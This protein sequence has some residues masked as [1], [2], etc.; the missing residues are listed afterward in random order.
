MQ[1]EETWME[2]HALHRHGWS[3][4][5]L[6]R[7]FGLNWRT[8]KK[9]ATRA[10]PPRYRPR[11]RPAELTAAQTGPRRA[12][13]DRLPR[14]AGDRPPARARRRVRVHRVVREPAP[15]G[16]RP[17]PG[18]GGGARPALRDG[19][20]RADPG[21]L[22]RLSAPGRSATGRP[23]LFAFV[24]ILGC[25][26]M[27]AHPLRDRQDAARRPCATS[28]AAS[29][30]S[31]GR[32]PTSCTTGTRRSWR[33]P[34]RT[35]RRS[36]RPSGSTPRPCSAR[37]P[38]PAGRT[39]PRPRARS[40]ASSGR[41]RRTSSPGSP[42]RCSPSA[43]RSPG[44]TRRRG[45]WAL[46]VHARRR[47]RTTGR[48]V[49][50]AWEAERPLLLPVSGRLV[51]R[52]EGADTLV[53]LPTPRER[54][55]GC[56][57]RPAR[58]SRSGRSRCTPSSPD[59]RPPSPGS[60]P[61]TPAPGSTSRTSASPRRRSTSPPS[62]SGPAPRPRPRSRSSS[63]CSRPRSRRPA[64]AGCRAGCGSPTTRS[65]S[66]SRSSSSTSSP[67]IDRAVIAELSTLRFVE[68]HRNALFLGPP[69]VGKSHLAIA[70][71]IAAT[72][73]GYRTYFTTAADLV[74]SLSAA[75]LEGTWTSK[76]RTYTGPSV[77]VIDEL[78][79]LPMDAT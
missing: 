52:V 24:A 25:S 50:E 18:D 32:R 29:T 40:S 51:A 34:A 13:P 6:A 37:A 21:R 27:V 63:G 3:I 54:R 9:Y 70:L 2:L 68:E 56:P 75:H 42:D 43:R 74:G 55:R 58:P 79:Y 16:R 30:T 46:E 38:G 67:R 1:S 31:A 47:H 28:S 23:T 35:A 8:A 76:M 61:R 48:V 65:T 15:A 7:E 73:A 5:D 53:P 26:R 44:T 17:A 69:G 60:R 22:G 33:A 36:T 19:P 57:L 64:P 49:G 62:S 41:S 20:R 59:E 72:E 66:A 12:A 10:E 14:P 45:R 77:L 4:A 39:G 71:G 11:V 78:G